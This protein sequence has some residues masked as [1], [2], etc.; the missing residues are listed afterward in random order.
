MTQCG[1]EIRVDF[2]THV[3]PDRLPFLATRSGDERWPYVER[4]DGSSARIMLGKNVYRKIGEAAWTAAARLADMEREQVDL[5]VVSP[6]PITFGYW[7]RAEETLE[8]ARFQNDFIAEFVSRNPRRFVGL[9]TVPMQAPELAVA[10]MRRALKELGLAGLEI[11]A[12][13]DGRGLHVPELRP[14][15]R[16]AAELSCPLFIHPTNE[17]WSMGERERRAALGGLHQVIGMTGE[18][19]FAAST[20]MLGGVLSELTE[21]R[22]CLA[23]GGGSLCMQVPRM[24]VI[25]EHLPGARNQLETSP[26]ELVRRFWAD[27]LSFDVDNLALLKARFGAEKLMVGTDYPFSARER[28]TGAV[29]DR[30]AGHAAFAAGELAAMRGENALRF[31]QLEDSF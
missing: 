12:T 11:G 1:C 30:A 7:G 8:L 16:A 25:W 18:T 27:T 22:V 20:L 6:T 26:M 4:E 19:A 28:P 14:F 29:I 24:A 31:L 13:V 9:G 17:P 3:F 5:Q 21:L 15:F 2:H 23:H 10:E